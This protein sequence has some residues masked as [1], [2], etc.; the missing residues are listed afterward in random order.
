MDIH[1]AP[2][3]STSPTEDTLKVQIGGQEVVVED[4]TEGDRSVGDLVEVWIMQDQR[5]AAD[6]IGRAS[7]SVGIIRES[8]SENEY[9]VERNSR[10]EICESL[11]SENPERGET[12]K[13]YGGMI[14]ST[15]SNEAIAP[16][17]IEDR[18]EEKSRAESYLKEP[19]QIS[20]VDSGYDDVGGLTETIEE[21]KDVVEIPL[22]ESDTDTNRFEKH[23]VKPDTGILFHGPPGTGKTLLAK[24]VAKETE[25]SIYL[26]NGP[27]II[28]KWYGET[29]DIIREIFSH[30]KEQERAI[31]FMDEVDSIAPDRGDTKQFQRKIVAQLLTE[32]D[33]FEPLNDVVVIGATNAL[34]EV[35]PAI[36]R[37]GRFDRKIEFSKP[38][39]PERKEIIEK[40]TKDVDFGESV[41]LELLAQSTEGWT[42]ADLSGVISRAVTISIRREGDLV[43]QDDLLRAV[44]ATGE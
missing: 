13:I 21:V 23:G 3:R 33:G 6:A 11:N 43:T 25:S 27:E 12:V 2:V 14:T 42:G 34:D 32:L 24:A 4:N 41:D 35:D 7:P 1:F 26:V 39:Q 9:L 38:T 18:F 29:E 20:E 16:K 17:G 40:I 37:P 15:I 30:A 22:R 5:V 10:V 36:I 28:N 44:E 19:E 8:V 31:I